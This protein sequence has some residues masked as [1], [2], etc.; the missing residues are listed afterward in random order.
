MERMPDP[1][2][3]DHFPKVHVRQ[4]VDEFQPGLLHEA[5]EVSGGDNGHPVAAAPQGPS[6]A[7]ERM[8]VSRTA[9][10]A[11]DDVLQAN[12]HLI[13]QFPVLL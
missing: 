10:H 3:T 5:A 1:R 9:N 11:K 7:D 12:A 6:Q 2:I 8:H 13:L 4:R